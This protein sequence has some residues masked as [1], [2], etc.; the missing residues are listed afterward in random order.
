MKISYII[1]A[2]LFGLC[3]FLY[4]KDAYD[5]HSSKRKDL[6]CE[7][8]SRAILMFTACF[9]FVLR[10]LFILNK[11]VAL[12]IIAIACLTIGLIHLFNKKVK[13][14]IIPGISCIGLLI[15]SIII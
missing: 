2:I 3:G 11:Q 7:N 15:L 6:F 1:A 12:V 13:L 4:A 10:N 5:N 14:A 8:I 9:L